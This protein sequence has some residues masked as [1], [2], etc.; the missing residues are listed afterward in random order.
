VRKY[1]SLFISLI[2]CYSGHD[3]RAAEPQSTPG[4]WKVVSTSGNVTVFRRFYPGPANY[5]SKA[6]GEIAAPV[7][8]VHAVIDD[9]ES[10]AKFMPYTA[11]C[12]VLKRE[13]NSAVA[14]QRLSPPLVGERDYTVLARTTSK[15][16]EGGMSYFMKW[17]AENALGPP[18]KPGVLR[19]NLCQGSWL[20]EPAGPDKTRV[21]Y[22]IL[23]D[24]GGVLPAFVKHT[25]S[26][27]GLRKMFT[28]IRKQVQDPKY[29]VVAK[30]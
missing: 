26:Q 12:R 27:M 29:I 19:V 15:A 20:L 14:Y 30:K 6:S 2:G 5:E 10:Y 4:E 16:V 17:D 25:G 22:T 21:T 7:E 11:E 8:R 28:A 9:L 24:S 23:T 13:G 1:L 18:E 3:A